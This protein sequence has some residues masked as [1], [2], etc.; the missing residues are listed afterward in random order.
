[1]REPLGFRGQA[2][3]GFSLVEVALA[4]GLLAFSLVAMLGVFPV[5]VTQ[6]A[7][8]V[9]ETRGIQLAHSVFSTLQTPPF[10]K[11]NCFGQTLNLSDLDNG[12][13]QLNPS[14]P[15]V[16]LFANYPASGEPTITSGS[17][18]QSEYTIG[19]W[20]HKIAAPEVSGFAAPVGTAGNRVT[21][22]ISTVNHSRTVQ[23]ASIIGNE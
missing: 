8:S 21:M 12:N 5:G 14:Q 16:V 17:S 11:V 19:L 15:Q 4:L 3:A 23:F 18:P 9:D 7:S 20:F 2:S 10:N 1:V 22:L 6:S 13:A